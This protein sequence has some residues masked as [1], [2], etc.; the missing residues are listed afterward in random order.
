MYGGV[1]KMNKRSR[2]SSSE[3]RTKAAVKRGRK[4]DLSCHLHGPIT[5]NG[6][7]DCATAIK[8]LDIPDDIHS[9]IP[10]AGC[11]RWQIRFVITP[12]HRLPNIVNCSPIIRY[13]RPKGPD[14]VLT[15]HPYSIPVP[16]WVEM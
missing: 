13:R 16:A 3:E 7:Y 9:I 15:F 6:T 2:G 11:G 10:M 12:P 1:R 14:S 5:D 4:V 8:A